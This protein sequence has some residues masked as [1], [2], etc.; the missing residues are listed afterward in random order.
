M[1][2]RSVHTNHPVSKELAMCYLVR[3][4]QPEGVPGSAPQPPGSEGLR[5]RWAGAAALA[6]MG[7]IALAATLVATPPGAP[8]HER[9]SERGAP[10]PVATRAAAV[11]AGA[12]E[13]TSVQMDDGVPASTTDVVKAGA[14]YCNRG[15]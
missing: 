1:S 4:H 11:P 6:L 12:V 3:Q 13:Q 14:G 5:S 8:Q 7:G 9:A 2:A 15:L 10:D